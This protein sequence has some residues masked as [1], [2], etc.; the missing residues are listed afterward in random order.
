M[1]IADR[2]RLLDSA[3]S[4]TGGGE[5]LVRLASRTIKVRSREVTAPSLAGSFFSARWQERG[6]EIRAIG[7]G[8]SE[9]EFLTFLDQLAMS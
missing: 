3:S 8:I 9:A 4:T 7:G 5:Q 1:V 6:F 2:D